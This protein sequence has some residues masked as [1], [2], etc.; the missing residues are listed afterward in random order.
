MISATVTRHVPNVKRILRCF[1]LLSG[2]KLNIRKSLFCG[3]GIKV[4]MLTS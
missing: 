4:N 2:L 1:Q 3:V